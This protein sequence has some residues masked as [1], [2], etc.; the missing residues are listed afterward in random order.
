MRAGW[1]AARS[2]WSVEKYYFDTRN[3]GTLSDTSSAMY[4]IFLHHAIL[5][6]L[7]LSSRRK[8]IRR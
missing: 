1:R 3:L 6:L 7:H 8:R 4:E 2:P 5:V